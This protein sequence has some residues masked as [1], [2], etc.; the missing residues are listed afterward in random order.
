[1]CMLQGACPVSLPVLMLQSVQQGEQ[2][3]YAGLH[4]HLIQRRSPP[5]ALATAAHEVHQPD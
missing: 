2:L 5:S 3:W 4:T 1:M